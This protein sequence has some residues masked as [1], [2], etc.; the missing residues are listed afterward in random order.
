MNIGRL[1]DRDAE[2]LA[3]RLLWEDRR[4]IHDGKVECLKDFGTVAEGRFTSSGKPFKN[5]AW[6]QPNSQTGKTRFF[7]TVV[8]RYKKIRYPGIAELVPRHIWDV[9]IVR[10]SRTTRTIS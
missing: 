4:P 3:A 1:K 5:L 6:L 8:L 7:T 2:Q 9:E 10:S